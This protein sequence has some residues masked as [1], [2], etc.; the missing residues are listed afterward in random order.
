[1][2]YCVSAEK[3]SK[4]F[5]TSKEAHNATYFKHHPQYELHHY[6]G[7]KLEFTYPEEFVEENERN[8]YS[9]TPLPIHTRLDIVVTNPISEIDPELLIRF[10]IRMF[11]KK[12][13]VFE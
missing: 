9:D 6:S 13:G 2:E 7:E 12:N 11:N 5:Q 4:E 10:N 3:F 8:K 1:M